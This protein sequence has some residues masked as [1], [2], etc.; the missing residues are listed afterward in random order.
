MGTKSHLLATRTTASRKPR[1]TRSSTVDPE[2]E[3]WANALAEPKSEPE[4]IDTRHAPSDPVRSESPAPTDQYRNRC[5]GSPVESRVL[6][7]C[8]C[9]RPDSGGESRS[10]STVSH[11]QKRLSRP[12]RYHSMSEPPAG[13]TNAASGRRSPRVHRMHRV[14]QRQRTE[15]PVETRVGVTLVDTKTEPL[16]RQLREIDVESNDP[17]RARG[18]AMRAF[19]PETSSKLMDRRRRGPVGSR[20]S[21][22]SIGIVQCSSRERPTGIRGPSGSRRTQPILEVS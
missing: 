9:A 7:T 21:V 8:Q 3:R 16:R 4:M 22:S 20:E 19:T 17:R 18:G 13:R 12:D 2:G 1:S 11:R 15:N 6:A 10:P 14:R 5:K